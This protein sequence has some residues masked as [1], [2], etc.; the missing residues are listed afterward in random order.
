VHSPAEAFDLSNA[1]QGT[2]RAALLAIALAR[3]P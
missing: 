1:W 2:A 3:Q